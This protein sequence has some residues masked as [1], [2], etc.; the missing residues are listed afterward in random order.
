MA[1]ACRN[2]TVNPVPRHG[3][4]STILNPEQKKAYDS[5]IGGME[6]TIG[7]FDNNASM[8]VANG[9][10]GEARE[11]YQ[12]MA[13]LTNLT[14][15]IFAPLAFHKNS[16][17]G[18]DDKQVTGVLG[19]YFKNSEQVAQGK[20]EDKPFYGTYQ[21]FTAALDPQ[22]LP[23]NVFK[24]EGNLSF[25]VSK[26]QSQLLVSR[27]LKPIINIVSRAENPE[28]A[29]KTLEAVAGA[30]S[31]AKTMYGDNKKVD[32]LV[33]F[34][35]RVADQAAVIPAAEKMPTHQEIEQK[36]RDNLGDKAFDKLKPERKEEL[37]QNAVSKAQE[38]YLKEI[39]KLDQQRVALGEISV[40][41]A[42]VDAVQQTALARVSAD[43]KRFDDTLRRLAQESPD[44]MN[45]SPSL[46]QTYENY[47]EADSHSDEMKKFTENL[48]HGIVQSVPDKTLNKALKP[49]LKKDEVKQIDSFV[50][51]ASEMVKEVF[52]KRDTKDVAPEYHR[53]VEM[54]EAIAAEGSARS[55]EEIVRVE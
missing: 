1:R 52:T 43:P 5:F 40:Y 49:E 51:A 8:A 41:K 28:A 15:A 54:G 26:G 11:S 23:Y 47:R 14:A 35:E 21:A 24:D 38:P 19:T 4:Q 39:V 20:A 10:T 45:S 55:R 48:V 13:N 34:V 31:A 46:R 50:S 37:I 33:S 44:W 18:I 9:K 25:D 6:R 7:A 16:T 36:L 29:Q 3:S 30:Y 32:S 22:N 27:E 53:V 2:L 17:G 42:E 12:S